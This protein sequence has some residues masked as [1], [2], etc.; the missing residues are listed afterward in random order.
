MQ[1][2][3]LVVHYSKLGLLDRATA[4]HTNKTLIVPMVAQG[5]Q[6]AVCYGFLAGETLL[7]EHFQVVLFAVRV[8][9]LLHEFRPAQV[10][11]A[12]LT[13]E[14]VLVPKFS[15]GFDECLF[16]GLVAHRT[17]FQ[18]EP[19]V[20]VLTEGHSLVRVEFASND[21][22]L[23]FATREVFRVPAFPQS[24]GNFSYD[25]LMAERTFVTHRYQEGSANDFN[26][27]SRGVEV[28][29]A[30]EGKDTGDR[31]KR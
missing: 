14:V 16:D 9:I 5:H 10:L 17:P 24:D 7:S 6:S 8:A 13:G 19:R 18:E 25:F 30:L 1:T 11:A 2:Q 15:Q 12:F 27:A 20:V 31:F 4:F 28:A 3:G 23:T 21:G 26:S 22:L 29:S